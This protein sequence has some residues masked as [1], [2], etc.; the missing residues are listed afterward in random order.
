MVAGIISEYNPFHSGHEYHIR[1][2]R[3]LLGEDCAVVAVMSGNFVQRG[4]FAVMEK[5]ARAAAA[6]DT[7]EGGGA[8]LVIELPLMYSL[9]SAEGFAGGA[10]GIMDA[11]GVVTHLSFGS[12]TGDMDP[13]RE[14]AELLLSRDFDE[15]LKIHLKT[16][17]SYAAARQKAANEAV[18]ER[19]GLLSQPNNI[20]AIEYLK[21]LITQNS[22]IEPLA[23]LRRG[24]MHDGAGEG[25]YPSASQVRELILSGRD[26]PERLM[27]RRS[28]AI[29][30]EQIAR[31]LAP[32]SINN[33]ER[34]VL[35]RMR[36]LDESDFEAA[37]GSA[38]G[39]HRRFMEAARR[40]NSVEGIIEAAKTKR[41]ARSRIRRLLLRAYLGVPADT[42]PPPYIRVLAFNGKGRGVLREVVK[43]AKLPVISKPAH[44]KKLGGFAAELFEMEARATDL[45]VLSF[46]D[47]KNAAGG[48]EWKKSV[49]VL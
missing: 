41:Y 38:E 25:E 11:L 8:D 39:F 32:A 16:G 24:V 13:L 20:L 40:E 49:Y 47:K 30:E 15:S 9:S 4:D 44:V 12:E 31:G 42:L 26:I 46:P 19:A 29:L 33:C 27:P 1:K 18:G 5:H 35:A 36:T 34:A 2:T 45:F 10:V 37:D 14:L 3:E 22:L 17:V 7:G 21:A 43:N 23:V 48:S 6:L 28:K